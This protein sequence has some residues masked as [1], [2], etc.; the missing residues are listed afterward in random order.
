MGLIKF[1]TPKEPH[2][3]HFNTSSARAFKNYV[4]SVKLAQYV[5]WK[6]KRDLLS[7]IFDFELFIFLNSLFNSEQFGAIIMFLRFFLLKL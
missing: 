6:A 1:L 7:G 5:R 4:V 3:Q 2:Q